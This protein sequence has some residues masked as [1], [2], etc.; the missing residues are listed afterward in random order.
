MTVTF[1]ISILG[2]KPLTN[3]ETY[4]YS[5]IVWVLQLMFQY[6]VK[7]IEFFQVVQHNHD[8]YLVHF[9]LLT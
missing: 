6:L 1:I 5:L 7:Y 3:V 4:L 9:L 8:F 2:K